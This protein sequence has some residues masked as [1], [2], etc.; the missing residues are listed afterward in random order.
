[1]NKLLKKFKKEKK[2]MKKEE[3]SEIAKT[4]KEGISLIHGGSVV[5]LEA[6][7]KKQT[8][9]TIGGFVDGVPEVEKASSEWENFEKPRMFFIRSSSIVELE[10]DGGYTIL[11]THSQF[12]LVME[13][14]K[15]LAT[16]IG[17]VQP[18]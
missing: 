12:F 2:E 1:M 11:K 9:A 6:S 7:A 16:R 14:I 13:E 10:E 4:F 3:W 8:C 18:E 15:A 5:S 17:W